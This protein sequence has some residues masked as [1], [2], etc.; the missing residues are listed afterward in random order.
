MK[1]EFNYY[2]SELDRVQVGF[3]IQIKVTTETNLETKWLNVN[4][5]SIPEIIKFLQSEKERLKA[6]NWDSSLL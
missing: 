2:R 6:I 3:P 1:K 5:E 4:L